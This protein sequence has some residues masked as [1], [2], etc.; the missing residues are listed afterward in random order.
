MPEAASHPSA[1]QLRDF[2]QGRLLAADWASVERHVLECAACANR[3]AQ[4]PEQNIADLLGEYDPERGGGETKGGLD[5]ASGTAGARVSAPGIQCAPP[6]LLD[7]PRYRVLGLLGSGGMG[8]VF[9]AE[10]RLM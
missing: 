3:I 6:E 7:H 5:A 8:M 1:D 4:L 10:H 2:D 9:K